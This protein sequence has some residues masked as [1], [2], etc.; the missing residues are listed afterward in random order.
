[1]TQTQVQPKG[2]SKIFEI[3]GNKM[4]E[5]INKAVELLK[6]KESFA[7]ATIIS[8][9]GSTPRHTGSRMLVQDDGS[10]V[11][12]VGGGI[13]EAEVQNEAL[14]A[15]KEKRGFV[16]SFKLTNE[17][18]ALE[19]MICGGEGQI[20]IDY[21]NAE[22]PVNLE[23]YQEIQGLINSD[24]RAWLITMIPSNEAEERARKQCLLKDD[25]SLVGILDYDP[26]L[27]RELASKSNKYDT[28][29]ILEK[30]N[31]LIEE[32]GNSK[33]AYIFGAGH[34]GQKLVPILNSVGFKTIVL[35]DR[36]EFA[37]KERCPLADEIIV[38]D[39]FDKYMEKLPINKN[40]FI[41]IVTRG[42]LHDKTVL[43][44]A[45]KTNAGYI[46]MIGSRIK[47]NKIYEDLMAEGFTKEDIAR[48][49]S[50]IGLPIKAESPE[51]IAISIAAE[52]IKVRA[53]MA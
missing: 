18:A 41:I 11:G 35:D 9:K 34:C 42:H 20:L 23:I 32:L 10:F 25:G 46:G 1:M 19:G 31:M 53:E 8:G 36:E 51:E 27:Y 2:R 14:D 47:R 28:F 7:L 38:I 44:D 49:H 12:T 6:N 15:I 29:T 13:L 52:L 33:T 26:E 5:V 37:N 39:S 4:Q 22:D 21:I 24:N 43:R 17:Q 3:G 30:R 45:L 48:V 40:S 50:P 16:Y